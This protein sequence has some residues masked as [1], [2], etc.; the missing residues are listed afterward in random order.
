MKVETLSPLE[1]ENIEY[2]HTGGISQNNAQYAFVPAFQDECDR[3]VE[4]SRFRDGRVAP[5]HTLD[6]LP[7]EWIVKRDRAGRIVAIRSSIVSGF[8]RHGRFFS[9]QEAA[10][11]V[12]EIA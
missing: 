6:G 11:Y 10:E 8:V 12:D 4:L 5:F 9:R 1:S 2:R 3:R 7:E